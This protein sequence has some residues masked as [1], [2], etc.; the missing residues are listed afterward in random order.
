MS[1]LLLD[2]HTILWF[3][4]DDPQLSC[5]AKSLIEESD[6]RILVSIASC[7]EISIKAGLVKLQLGKSSRAFL[8]REIARN[9]FE[10]LAI[11]LNTQRW[12]KA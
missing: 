2:S 6:N 9:N 3:F 4:W 10:L 11:T 8:K 1:E 7:W 5:T 12:S